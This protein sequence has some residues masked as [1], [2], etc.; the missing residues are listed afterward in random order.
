[1]IQDTVHKS[2]FDLTSQ[3]IAYEQGEL[4]SHAIVDLFQ[5]LIDTGLAWR[6]QGHYGRQAISL[7]EQGVCTMDPVRV[8]IQD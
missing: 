2:S 1:M 5:Y 7:I 6:L 8:Q 4:D 3:I